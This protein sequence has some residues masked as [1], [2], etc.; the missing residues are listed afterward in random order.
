[1]D[2]KPRMRLLL[3]VGSLVIALTIAACGA[4]PSTAGTGYAPSAQSPAAQSP[5]TQSGTTPAST[6]T[7]TSAV[8]S[9]SP[10]PIPGAAAVVLVPGTTHYAVSDTITI[11]VQNTT[12]RTI[13]ALAQ[14]TGCSIISLEHRVGEN[15]QP[16]Q[17][18]NGGSPHPSITPIA[19]G[20]EAA[21]QLAAV[22]A[23]SGAGGGATTQWPT[24]TYRAELTYTTSASEPFGQGTPA[25]SATF[26]IGS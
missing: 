25:Y 8:A 21:I 19:P 9:P 7:T 5:A 22:T 17:L 6:T 15:W 26:V 10:Q 3:L 12:G 4:T 2:V 16:V 20:G 1:M 24:G 11:T 23:S 13:Y 18:C 14:F